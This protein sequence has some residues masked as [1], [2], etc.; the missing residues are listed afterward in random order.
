M[1]A[2]FGIPIDPTLLQVCGM[3]FLVSAFSGIL[4][5]VSVEACL[6]S[7]SV[8]SPGLPPLGIV[9]AAATGQMVAKYAL[10]LGGRGLVRGNL[11]RHDA[12]VRAVIS[13]LR[14]APRRAASLLF[15]SALTGMPPFYV[16]SVAAGAVRFPTAGFFG[17]GLAG[18][19]LRFGAVFLVPKIL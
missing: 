14:A 2:V 15:M 4:P 5:L 3:T 12:R 1:K 6:I 7:A 10:F 9:L 8:L 17:L 16:V 19:L 18:R 11:G 13:R